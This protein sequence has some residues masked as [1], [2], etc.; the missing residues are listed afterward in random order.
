MQ[1]SKSMRYRSHSYIY[2]NRSPEIVGCC[3]V[4]EDRLDIFKSQSDNVRSER[5]RRKT[6]RPRP[7]IE[8][9][10]VKQEYRRSGIGANLLQACEDAVKLWP[11]YEIFAQVEEGNS[12]AFELFTKRGYQ[13]LFADP[14]CT[15][16]RL[17]NATFGREVSV[18]KRMMRKF[19]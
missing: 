16:V 14:T 4:I 13:Y 2:C 9:L 3:E 15:E 8:N 6:A 12:S 1:C 19:L 5:E 7:V 11:G 18:T 10:C 17:D